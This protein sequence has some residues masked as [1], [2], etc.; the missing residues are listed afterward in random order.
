MKLALPASLLALAAVLIAAT[1][2]ELLAPLGPVTIEAARTPVLRRAAP[3]AQLAPPSIDLF[4]DIDARP[5]FNPKRVPLP[6]AGLPGTG[7]GSASD[8][9]LIG[10]MI[11]GDKPIAL[12]KSRSTSS[13]TSAT[14]GDIVAGMRVVQ[15]APTMVALRGSSGVVDVQLASLGSQA[16]SAPLPVPAAAS[17]SEPATSHSSSTPTPS[18]LA[19]LLNLPLAA[20]APGKPAAAVATAPAPPPV[21]APAKPALPAPSGNGTIAAEALKG[22]PINP[23]TGEPTL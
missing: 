3:V 16:P 11:G 1:S 2:Y 8:L 14:I 12:F 9:T 19:G 4:A 5:L 20:A 23:K 7:S 6:D 21:T 18:A 10:V 15:I 17:S 22:A 13:S